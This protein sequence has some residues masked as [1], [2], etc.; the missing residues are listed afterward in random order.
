MRKSILV[1][2][3]SSACL[4]FFIL[5][6]VIMVSSAI[7]KP[8]ELVNGFFLEIGD[9]V[10]GENKNDVIEMIERW[11]SLDEGK[12]YILELYVPIVSAEQEISVPINY[13]LI[14]NIIVGLEDISSEQ[15]EIMIDCMKKAI[16]KEVPVIDD[17]GEPVKDEDGNEI[18]ETIIEYELREVED[19]LERLRQY[20]PWKSGFGTVS[21]QT[22]SGYVEEFASINLYG[23]IGNEYLEGLKEGELLYPFKRK[24]NITAG[25]GWYAP[26]G[27][28][29]WHPAIDL[30][31]SK[32]NQCGEA[33]YAI[34]DGKVIAKQGNDISKTGN[35]VYIQNGDMV[36]KYV[37]MAEA[38]PYEIGH[39]VK[40]GDYIGTVGATGVATGCHLH[41][42][43]EI[44]GEAVNPQDYI[45]FENPNIS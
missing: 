4:L 45:D 41:L 6:P 12:E 42:G 25:F 36:M 35:Y 34:G 43:I 16:E 13:L 20:E 8:F 1:L 15:F 32:P 29:E 26:F 3:A 30:A 38:Y 18:L 28:K 2:A 10:F 37:H 19:Y 5:L 11:I 21:T 7:T 22:V 24:A 40:Q 14:P 44:N 27:K 23:G 31:F 17:K 33:I 39:E 9:C